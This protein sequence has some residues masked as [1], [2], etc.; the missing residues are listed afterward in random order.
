M[1]SSALNHQTIGGK[2]AGRRRNLSPGPV[3]PTAS[4]AAGAASRTGKRK[5][6]TEEQRHEIEEAVS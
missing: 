1:Y 6:L 3:A 4:G 2:L 5:E